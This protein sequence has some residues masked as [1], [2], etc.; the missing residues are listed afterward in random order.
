MFHQVMIKNLRRKTG[1]IGWMQSISGFMAKT[2]AKVNWPRV[3]KLS[4]FALSFA[5][6]IVGL[7][8]PA[9]RNIVGLGAALLFLTIGLR[10]F[11]KGRISLEDFW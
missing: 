2:S 7:S 9:A 10:V 11:L 6:I 3:R 5:M 8:H 4:P 1:E